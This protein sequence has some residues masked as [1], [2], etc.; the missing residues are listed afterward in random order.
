LAISKHIYIGI[1]IDSHFL[2]GG[3][4]VARS[5]I[6]IKAYEFQRNLANAAESY[7]AVISSHNLQHIEQRDLA[8]LNTLRPVKKRGGVIYLSF[9]S[10]RSLVLPKRN[11]L[12]LNYCGDVTHKSYPPCL[13]KVLHTLI[14][15]GF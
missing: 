11:P 6:I 3:H 7:D 12:T 13:S 9:P 4:Q 10:S 14:N 1:D 8:L 15:S 2:G 5:Y